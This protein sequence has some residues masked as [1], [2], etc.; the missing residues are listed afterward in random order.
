MPGAPVSDDCEPPPIGVV[1]NPEGE[2]V[3]AEL[4][5]KAL[6]ERLNAPVNTHDRLERPRLDLRHHG[7]DIM[8]NA[9][10]FLEAH[11][12]LDLYE[13]EAVHGGVTPMEIPRLLF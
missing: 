11:P 1:P 12:L 5:G 3:E 6:P 8:I 13:P 9:K 10:G 4:R 2:P 7:P